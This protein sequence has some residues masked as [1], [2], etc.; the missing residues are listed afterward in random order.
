MI[1][2][3]FWDR[4]WALWAY[5]GGL[6]ILALLYSQVSISVRLNDWYG[7][8][9]S[10]LQKATE[11]PVSEFYA[12]LIKF[13]WLATPYIFLAMIINFFT[14]H[15]AFRWRKAITFDYLPR[16]RKVPEKIEGESQRIQEDA[17]KFAQ[18]VESL[19]LMV[20]K[21][22]MTLIAFMPILWQL[23]KHV[24]VPAFIGGTPVPIF[25]QAGKII[26]TI[27]YFPGSLVWLALILSIGG[28]IISWLVG[29]RLPKLQ[30]N[31]QVVEAAFRKELV[32]G[33]DNKAAHATLPT[34]IELFTG[35][36][37]NYKR[38]F[39][40]FSYYDTWLNFYVL[41]VEITPYLIVA[42][43]LFSGA[44][45]LGVMMQVSNAFDK[46][47]AGFSLF[48]TNWT[49][50]TELR[51]IWMRLHEFETKMDKYQTS[52]IAETDKKIEKEKEE[53]K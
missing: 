30:Y 44:M 37:F 33:E 13:G 12:C 38:L 8:F 34:M 10:L 31:N 26:T 2:A 16:W 47:Q 48:A 36:E 14:R 18:I 29:V 28:S 32:L 40:N 20:I 24:N 21:T 50:V 19:G 52:D 43:N 27:N 23:S 1:K 42:P 53:Q 15:Y 3:F 35:L 4:K 11:H 41:S 9:Y 46:V 39:L 49:T 5:G 45:L 7:Q 51:S 6:F 22:I 17:Q 25:D